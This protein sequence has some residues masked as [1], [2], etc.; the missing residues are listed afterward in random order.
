M[1]A[2]VKTGKR[3][4]VISLRFCYL[5]PEAPYFHHLLFQIFRI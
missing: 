1:F 2:Y 4:E 5:Q 3:E